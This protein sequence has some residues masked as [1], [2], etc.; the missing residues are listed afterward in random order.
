M[1]KSNTIIAAGL[2]AALGG[3][4]PTPTVI[5]TLTPYDPAE[6]RHIHDTGMTTVEGQAFLRTTIGEVRTCAGREANLIPVTG[7]SRE[8]MTNL[9]ESTVQGYY[10]NYSL[11][12]DEPDPR[13]LRDSRDGICDAEGDFVFKNVPPG[14]YFIVTVVSWCVPTGYGCSWQ[15]G[16]LMRRIEVT[17]SED[18]PMRVILTSN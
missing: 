6:A 2:A 14:D 18:A 9:Y 4:A 5:S 12:L 7:Y 8:R 16:S 15:G 17:G 11:I 3:C 13:Y 1:R 10:F